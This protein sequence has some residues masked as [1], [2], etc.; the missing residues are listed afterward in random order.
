M[1]NSCWPVLCCLLLF[2][3][4]SQQSKETTGTLPPNTVFTI[5]G[6]PVS[7][8]EFLYVYQKNSVS[9][10]TVSSAEDLREYLDL[11]INFKLKVRE[12]RELGLHQEASFQEE[13]ETYKKQLARPYLTETSVTEQLVAEAYER[14]KTEINAAHILIE[15]PQGA[16][17]ADTLAAWQ[18]IEEIR[19]QAQAGADFGQ[20]A[21]RFSDDPSAQNNRGNLGYFTALQMVYPFEN[22]AYNTPVGAISAPVRTRFGYHIL[23]V[24]DKRPSQ[25][26]TRVA[27]LMVRT[28]PDMSAEAQQAAKARIEALYGQLRAGESWDALVR[29]FSE[30]KATAAKGGE[31][32]P[33]GT[34]QMIPEFEKAA[35]S[36]KE[37]ESIA[38]PVKT[39]YGWHIIKLLER[40]TLPPLEEIRDELEARVSRDSR[41]Q[42]QEEVLITRLKNE[43]RLVENKAAIDAL[44]Q[45]ADSSLMEGKWQYQPDTSTQQVLF[46]IADSATYTT[47]AF[48]DWVRSLSF[49]HQQGSP[50]AFINRLY[51]DWQKMQLIRY[52]E[53]HLTEKYE[54]YRML[55]QEY[56]DGILLFQLMEENVWGKALQDTLGLQQ[57]FQQ[58]QDQYQWQERVQGVLLNAAS[59][60]VLQKAENML[61]QKPYLVA[62][63]ALA[64]PVA[65]EGKLLSHSRQELGQLLSAMQYRPEYRLQI[66]APQAVAEV[67]RAQMQ[68]TKLSA[69]RY[70]IK[71]L[72]ANK[73]SVLRLLSN[74]PSALEPIFGAKDPLSLQVVEGPFERG[75]NP[76]VDAVSWAPG[77][78]RLQ[79]DGRSFLV[80]VEAVLPPG[81]KSLEEVRGQAISDYQNHLEQEW[82]ARL[83]EKYE[84]R[85]NDK[86]FE[87]LLEQVGQNR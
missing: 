63:K 2:A 33:F 49:S 76:V 39:P 68:E 46:T 65:E 53:E 38:P 36:L 14:M 47:A 73:P 80:V 70:E 1:R 10:D 66:E 44:F 31:L 67:F 32:P 16:A 55:V 51:R 79:Q 26:K 48:V 72:A 64:E 81:P 77:R 43:N 35:F 9:R 75:D 13:L 86:E 40:E 18:K 42:L 24:N 19:Q 50:D 54:D 52:E 4:K 22:A 6:D 59:D 60:T 11:Y 25:G 41:S 61:D 7:E 23:K 62:N 3:C 83:R 20:L 37:K 34:G 5:A 15:V 85:V 82:V 57:Y 78:Y 8:Q 71:T 21:L 69:D 74:S 56:H 87:K 84:V 45:Q 27:H 28:Q 17:P 58:H 29:Q 12:A 30:D